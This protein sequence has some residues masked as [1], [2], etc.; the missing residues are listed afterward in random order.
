MKY[1]VRIE[2]IS[3]A[4]MTS[5]ESGYG[6]IDDAAVL[7]QGDK[8]GWVGKRSE[9]PAGTADK[10]VDGNGGLLTPG[11]IDC[12][13]HLIYGGS[14]ASEFEELLTGTSYTE[15]LKR[16]GGILS[17]VRDTRNASLEELTK[18]ANRRLSSLIKEGVTTVEIK[19]GYGLDFETERKII[20][21]MK[22]LE[23]QTDITVKKTFL[24][25]HAVP[26]EY[27]KKSDA[28]IELVC[29]K[30]IPAFAGDVDYA[31]VFCESIAFSLPQTKR[32]FEAAQQHGLKIRVHAEQ[33]SNMGAASLA[34]EFGALSADHLE[35][36]DEAGVRNMADRGTTAVLLPGAFYFLRE[37]KIP[38]IDLFRR[39]SVPM[40]VSTDSNPGSSPCLSIL[41]MLNMACTLFHLTPEEALQGVTINAV[42]ALGLENECGTLEKGKTA[43]MALFNVKSPAEL[44]YTMGGNLCVKVWKAGKP[45]F[46]AAVE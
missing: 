24:G 40:A 25:A 45:V 8:I 35:Y 18:A 27:E 10:T 5:T 29:N 1:D 31:D 44:A 12:H 20:Q 42:K 38:P 34:S 2:N 36:I 15:I 13:T 37:K 30:M 4:T 21:A 9:A 19:T 14:R 43:D 32:V 11:L 23:K 3:A 41:L 7:V 26:R 39:Y 6:L 16:G 46:S 17:T 33:L 28:Y 22:N